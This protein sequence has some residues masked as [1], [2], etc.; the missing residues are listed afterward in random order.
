MTKASG[1][2]RS[3][4]QVFGLVLAAG[5][6]KRMGQ[7]KLL[8][9]VDEDKTL[10]QHVLNNAAKADLDGFLVVVSASDEHLKQ[11]TTDPAWQQVVNPHAKEG[12][13]TSIRV[14]VSML[15]RSTADA[16]VVLLGDMPDVTTEV[17]NRVVN[18]FRDELQSARGERHGVPPDEQHGHSHSERGTSAVDPQAPLIVQASYRGIPSHPVLF[19]RGLFAELLQVDGDEGG[20]AVIAKHKAQRILVEIESDVPVDLDTP[21]R[22]KTWLESKS[23]RADD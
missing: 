9:K 13:S 5:Q 15:E 6:S 11:V 12:M 8:L 17:I 14:G 23:H 20:K 18:R 7:Q 19:S 22:Y 4:A 16:V 1:K 2:D 10:I 21:E 3:R